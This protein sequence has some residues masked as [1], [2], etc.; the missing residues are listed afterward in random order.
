MTQAT[1]EALGDFGRAVRDGLSQARKSIPAR[2]FYDLRGSE[3][4]E[5][6]TALPEYYP[7]RTETAL[8]RHHAGD[9]GR[10]AG[11]GRAVIEFG[12]GSAT[13]TPLLLAATEAATYVPV[14][15]SGDFLAQSVAALAR[16]HPGLRIVPVAGDF[17]RPMDLPAL[18][19]PLTGFF[20]GSTIGN[21]DPRA[22]VDLLRSFRETLGEGA[23][24]VIG[25]DTRKNA[26]LL[27]AAYDDAAGVTAAF[28]LNL[29][30]RI[31]RELDGTI[32]VDAFEHR[33]VWNDG[34]GRVEMH[35][36]ATRAVSFSAA[37]RRFSMHPGETIHSENSYK[38]SLAEARLL[39]RA[40]GWE[41][42]A[43]WSDAD[44]MFGLHVW[45]AAGEGERS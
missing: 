31:N 4:F 29:L 41:P 2:Y 14:D 38:Y 15:I 6:I 11:R 27:E 33:A 30:E 10:L 28:N 21:F 12:A 9:L 17:S 18:P 20:P 25:I 35:L 26:R 13:K 39:A 36:A 45:A 40:S 42:I 3:L 23:R 22:A 19:R 43:F 5:E 24:L 8:L 7:T 37:G 44:D 16:S 32:P 34:Q 1:A